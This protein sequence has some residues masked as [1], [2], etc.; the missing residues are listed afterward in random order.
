MKIEEILQ[1]IDS[2][3]SSALA[4][5]K[6]E[7]GGVK[8]SLK[9]AVAAGRP[10]LTEFSECTSAVG[11]TISQAEQIASGTVPNIQVVESENS[12]DDKSTGG[13]QGY[14][15]KSPLV[16]TFYAASSEDAKPFVN[17]GDNVKEGQ[18]LA[19]VEAMK[20]MNDIESDFTGTIAE[21]LVQNGETVEYGQPLFV[22]K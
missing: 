13:V 17:I 21:I 15:V 4:E 19:I 11:Q 5:F 10:V 3:S 12:A 2:V 20:L 18:V 1:L 8:L 16:G 14:I 9:K 6:Y 22:I 7:E